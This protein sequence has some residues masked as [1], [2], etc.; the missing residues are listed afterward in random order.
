MA[1]VQGDEVAI[2]PAAA[3]A[4]T[5]GITTTTGNFLCAVITVGSGPGTLASVS[6]SYGNTWTAATGN[7]RAPNG[8]AN[9]Y[10]YWAEN[11]T[12]GAGHTFT[13]N[14]NGSRLMSIGLVELSGR[15]TSSAVLVQTGFLETVSGTSHSSGSSGALSE[16][17]CDMVC[18][19]GDN[20]PA[21]TSSNITYTATSTG[22]TLSSA[23]TVNTVASGHMTTIAM[24]REN[25]DTSAQEATWTSSSNAKRA[26]GVMIAVKSASGGASTTVTPAQAALTLNG[27]TPTT[28]AFQ[29]VRI[30]EVLVNGSGQTVGNATDI[31]LLVWYSGRF[32]GAPDV[33]LNGFTTDSQGT[34]SWSIATGTLAFNDPIAW[35]AQNS[36]SLS[37]YAAARMI[38]SYE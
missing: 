6:D 19:A 26:A 38:P 10:V 31:T 3:S 11:I 32:G 21:V 16:S 5:P 35:V 24:Y 12:G 27:R 15:A 33:S 1:F 29:N 4:T 14:A 34:T 13:A 36:V 8:Q 20:S 23:G 25:V 30:R 17:G 7:P 37:H 9:V 18:L 22:W 28:S 2:T